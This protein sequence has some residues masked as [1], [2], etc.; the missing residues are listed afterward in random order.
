[1][2]RPAAT[3]AARWGVRLTAGGALLLV[4]WAALEFIPVEEPASPGKTPNPSKSSWYYEPLPASDYS[5]A[6]ALSV[7]IG[8]VLPGAGS[9]A[10]AAGLGLIIFDG[11]RSR[12]RTGHRLATTLFGILILLAGVSLVGTTLWQWRVRT[13]PMEPASPGT[14]REIDE[15]SPFF[16]DFADWTPEKS[17]AYWERMRRKDRLDRLWW[18]IV[19]YAFPPIGLLLA[20][21]G[22]WMIAAD[23]RP[24]PS[25]VTM[26][27]EAR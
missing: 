14:L 12:A 25:R 9:L 8:H 26:E 24:R 10:L 5:L 23:H 13:A 20:A 7:L 27:N 1:V 11:R 6:R 2:D 22:I 16:G 17:D 3:E 21:T 15:D 19:L 18:R 4:A